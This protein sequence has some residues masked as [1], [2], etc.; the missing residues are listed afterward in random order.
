MKTRIF[1]TS[2][3]ASALVALGAW[4]GLQ[5]NG[6]WLRAANAQSS[7][8]GTQPA[9]NA[10]AQGVPNFASIVEANKGSVVNIT[11]SST[12]KAAA[13]P[14]MPDL[15]GDDPFSQFFRRFQGPQPELR[16]RG[17]GS[18][19]VIGADGLI[20]TN[21]HVVDGATQVTVKFPDRREYKAKVLG[22][23]KPSDIAVIKIDAKGLK[24][25][26]LG[27][28][29]TVQVG[30]WVLAIGSPYGFENSVTAGIV[31]ATSRALPEG[32][33]VPFIQTDAAVNPGNS[34]GPLFNLRGEV[35]GINSQIYSQTGG[36]QG[37]A[38]AIPI[39]VAKKVE[40][41][42]VAHGSVQRGRIGVGIQELTQPLAESFGLQAPTGALVGSVDKSGPAAKAGIQPGDVLLSLNGKPIERSSDLPPRVADL[43][44][45]SKATLE[46]WRNGGK[47]QVELTVGELKPEKV[48]SAGNSAD[49][50]NGR[51]GLA[52]RALT[53]EEKK[54]AEIPNG[55][56]VEQ[57]S[58]PAA[59][60]GI[61]EGDVILAVNGKPVKSPADL[62]AAAGKA[63][64]VVALL[65]Q[66]EDAKIFVPVEV[67]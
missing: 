52:V 32:T 37:L 18:G 31:S 43:K 11:V 30:E 2:L 34:G 14:Q 29:S 3:A 65:I 57:A 64:K 12:E 20:M 10:P 5:A 9:A 53:D 35:I 4:G 51:L 49:R 60:A 1:V 46:L 47:K 36:Y 26:K 66:R 61:R 25:V 8:V 17:L 50:D 6:S 44:P 24:P 62:R 55:L 15:G 54:Q 21:A 27:D 19:F 59:Q 42:L 13:A 45:G 7:S 41:Q 58:G 40:T 56:V 67:G 23:D 39:D 48:A 16:K 38:F 63:G 33:Y 28:P 22:I